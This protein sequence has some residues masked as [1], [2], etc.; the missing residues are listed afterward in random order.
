MK[1]ANRKY[2][3][4]E[5][6]EAANYGVALFVIRSKGADTYVRKVDQLVTCY[7]KNENYIYLSYVSVLIKILLT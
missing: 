5:S 2:C 6:L 4:R 3:L 7:E 1:H